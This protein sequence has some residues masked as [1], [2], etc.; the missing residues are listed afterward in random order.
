MT[1]GWVAADVIDETGS[2]ATANLP[3]HTTTHKHGGSDEVATATAGA[4]LIPKAGAGGTLAIAWIPTGSTSSTACIGNDSRLSDSRAPNGTAAG[5]LAGS[6]PNPTIK[7]SVSLTTP[8]IG[9]ATGTS[10]V[11][12][13]AITSSG[14]GI[15]YA[16]GNGGTVTQLTSKATGVTLNKLC[17]TITMN[18]AA[19]AAAT[20]VSFTVTNSFM[21]ATDVVHVQHDTIGAIGGYT[22]MPNTSAAGSFRVSVRNNTAGS[23]SEAIVLRFAIVKAVTS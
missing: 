19:L 4:N 13:G 18:G 22:V 9:A 1:N 20:I 11:V 6:Y 23:L 7:A 14:G 16:T 5:D 12:T 2:V 17:G 3:A 8:V 21:A 15:G 10:L